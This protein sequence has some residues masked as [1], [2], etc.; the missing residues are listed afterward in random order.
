MIKQEKIWKFLVFVSFSFPSLD[1]TSGVELRDNV[2]ATLDLESSLVS[3]EIVK[4]GIT[5][6]KLDFGYD[7]TF[8]G[9]SVRESYDCTLATVLDTGQ[10]HL[11]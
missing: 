8:F 4:E 11:T 9:V 3:T 5:R 1:A 10:V 2:F 6:F 7:Q